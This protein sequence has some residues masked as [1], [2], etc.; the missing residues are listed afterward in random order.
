ME[1]ADL[2]RLALPLYGLADSP[3][4]VLR[5]LGDVV[6]RVETPTGPASLRVC[7]AGTVAARLAEITAF[8]NAAAGTG[9]TIPQREPARALIL[10]D[11]TQ[12]WT[13]RSTWV[14]GEAPR[15]V[16]TELARKLGQETAR[17]H[18]LDFHPPQNWV[19]PVYDA[20]WRG[21]GGGMRP[22]VT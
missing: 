3:F 21:R 22:H 1:P 14:E 8:Q 18:A 2:I 12:R 10:P 6:A 16:T 9:L 13:V 7:E 4:T 11:G 5:S 20:T 17:F 15:P 19:G